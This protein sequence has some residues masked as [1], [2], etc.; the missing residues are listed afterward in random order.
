MAW[1]RLEDMFDE[2]PK[3]ASLSDRGFRLWVYSI[4][5]STRRRTAGFLGPADVRILRSKV[6]R[7][8]SETVS[9]LVRKGFWERIE[10]GYTIHDYGKYHPKDSTSYI[11]QQRYRD[12]HPNRDA[13][14]DSDRNEGRDALGIVTLPDPDP[15]LV[16]EGSGKSLTSQ[17]RTSATRTASPE[18]T[19][20]GATGSTRSPEE[21]LDEI[22]ARRKLA[23]LPPRQREEAAPKDSSPRS[24]ETT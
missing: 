1:S 21:E 15:E 7:S 4:T 5:Y 18:A 23:G 2:N 6:E 8:G 17:S 11:R 20:P 3:V 9:E 14:R 13:G 10:G 19:P 12:R 22:N 16:S 24:Q